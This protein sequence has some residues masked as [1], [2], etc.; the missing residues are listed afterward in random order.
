MARLHVQWIRENGWEEAYEIFYRALKKLTAEGK[1]DFFGGMTKKGMAIT[2]QGKNAL[3][4]VYRKDDP[5]PVTA[6][7]F[8][9]EGNFQP[10]ADLL[11]GVPEEKAVI[12]NAIA[13]RPEL[14][15][16]GY[17]RE[18]MELCVRY[19]KRI[20]LNSVVGTVHPKNSACIKML[21][22][23][24]KD[25]TV[26]MSDPYTWETPRGRVLERRR[27]AFEI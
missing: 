14:W 25:G 19:M 3:I 24:S 1:E 15:G 20:G 4:L 26:A 7:S 18:S 27:F 22:Y 5:L 16:Q 23:V 12:L 13:V 2:R 10:Y 11:Q 8:L 9:A 6:I 21:E 17:A